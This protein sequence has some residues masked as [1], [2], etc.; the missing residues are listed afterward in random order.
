M[1]FPDA[2]EFGSGVFGDFLLDV[3][4]VGLVEGRGFAVFE[5]HQI[6]V[7]LGGESEASEDFEGGG[8]YTA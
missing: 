5:D 6:E 3:F 8:G 2:V 7:L 4:H 1:F